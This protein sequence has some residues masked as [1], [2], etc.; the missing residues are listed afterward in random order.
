MRELENELEAAETSDEHISIGQE[1]D[2][3]SDTSDQT[4]MSASI[5]DS[6]QDVQSPARDS[7]Q[8]PASYSTHKDTCGAWQEFFEEKLQLSSVREPGL[9]YNIYLTRPKNGGV[10]FLFHHG[11]GSSGLSFALITAELESL[12]HE[13]G[14]AAFE[15]RGHGRTAY[16]GS[17]NRVTDYSLKTL[18]DDVQ[19][20][21]S[22]LF[23]RRFPQGQ[24]DLVLV[25][26]SMG[27]AVVSHVANR[28]LRVIGLVVIDVVEGSAVDAFQAMQT[29]LS[30]RPRTFQTL[31]DAVYWHVKSGTIRLHKS[32]QISV[33]ELLE[34]QTK[35][36][37]GAGEW[38]W[39]TDLSA[40]QNFW[41]DWFNGLSGT[42]L[43]GRCGKLLILA[44]TDRLDKPLMIAH[45]QGLYQLAV[46]PNSGHFVHEDAP[47]QV[48]KLLHDMACRYSRSNDIVRE[49]RKKFMSPTKL[50]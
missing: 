20:C 6:D 12:N 43:S 36:I 9:T 29:Y 31:D 50:K 11:A 49:A 37:I 18:C 10:L 22:M 4:V 45:M 3:S 46:I 24:P 23:S 39:K 44:G 28:L 35:S 8:S 19:E 14:Y 48:A 7:T 30:S 41:R 25:G 13:Y 34:T 21:M 1:A 16:K 40:T 27:G 26:H 42:F 38:T 47:D 17:D 32:A 15:A 33:P 5:A 2:A